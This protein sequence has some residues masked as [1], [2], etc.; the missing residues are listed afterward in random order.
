MNWLPIS[1]VESP[2][3]SYERLPEPIMVW[4]GNKIQVVEVARVNDELL[5]M[6]EGLGRAVYPTHWMPLPTPPK[7]N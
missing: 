2:K 4:D 1:T 3:K 6:N 7:G 5:F